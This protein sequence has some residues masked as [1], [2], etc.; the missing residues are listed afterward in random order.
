MFVRII[1][2]E[3]TR[4]STQLGKKQQPLL[5]VQQSEKTLINS[6]ITGI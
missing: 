2:L 1:G 4:L 5:T 3:P 6:M